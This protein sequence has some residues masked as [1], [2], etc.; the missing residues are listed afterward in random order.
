MKVPDRGGVRRLHFSTALP[1][2]AVTN[3]RPICG[4]VRGLSR[5]SR[6]LIRFTFLDLHARH[7]VG[8]DESAFVSLGISGKNPLHVCF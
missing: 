6:C 3:F 1:L 2:H 4:V 5:P 8:K 7:K